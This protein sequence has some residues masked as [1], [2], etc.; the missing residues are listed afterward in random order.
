MAIEIEKKFLLTSDSW[1]EGAS[2][3]IYS[4][5]YLSKSPEK[6][7]RV[8]ITETGAYLTIKGRPAVKDGKIS[9]A[10]LEFEYS[11]PKAD[12]EE[13]LKNLCSGPIIHKKRYCIEYRGFTWEVDEFFGENEGL[14]MAEIEL[15][16]EDQEFDLP[17]WI[18]EEV[19][20]D[21]RYYN[22]SLSEYPY[23]Q[24]GKGITEE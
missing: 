24:W 20:S 13:L 1:R 23:S 7:V 19:T 4:Q 3:Q 10:K 16:A 8:R 6:T 18:G 11:I 14:L 2:G 15:E 12:A 9:A 22:A 21:K 5:G 17:P